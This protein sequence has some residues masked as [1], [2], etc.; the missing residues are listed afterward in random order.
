MIAIAGKKAFQSIQ[1]VLRQ[2]KSVVRLSDLWRAIHDELTIG[3][4]LPG[5][6]L[7]LDTEDRRR[8]REYIHRLHGLDPLLDE[9]D[10]DRVEI[11][12]R[13]SNEKFS[14]QSVFG[15]F[16]RLVSRQPKIHLLTGCASTP[17][18]STLTLDPSLIMAESL[19]AMVVVVENG[20]V[21]SRWHDV[22]IADPQAVGA[23]AIYRGHDQEARVVADWLVSLPDGISIV[24]AVDFDPAGFE[25]ALTLGATSILLPEDWSKL[26]LDGSMNKVRAFDEQYRPELIERIPAGWLQAYEWMVSQR[27]A[28]TQETLLAR[29]VPLQLLVR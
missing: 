21:F 6:M 2:D 9:L 22:P 27:A 1:A 17:R 28:F 19:G 29:G 4:R 26:P 13:T 15:R 25:I 23:L 16:L 3:V 18:G 20:A 5:G 8:L 7:R 11:A 10:G 12:A 14:A 24:A